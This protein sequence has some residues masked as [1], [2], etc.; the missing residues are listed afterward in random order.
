M[1][2]YIYTIQSDNKNSGVEI[3]H[4]TKEKTITISGWYD[5][6]VGIE[7]IMMQIDEFLEKLHIST[8]KKTG[9][10]NRKV[11][12]CS[13]CRQSVSRN[14][15]LCQTN[16]LGFDIKTIFCSKCIK[17][18][19]APNQKEAEKIYGFVQRVL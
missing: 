18:G 8:K 11:E 7:P 17:N 15:L 3:K 10:T 5:G 4:N 14:Y 16:K 1:P 6:M 2:K 12:E 13:I 19:D 9:A